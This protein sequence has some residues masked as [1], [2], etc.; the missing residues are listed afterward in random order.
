MKTLLHSSTRGS[1]LLVAM[2]FSTVLAIGLGSYLAMATSALGMSRRSF[3]ANEAMNVTEAGLEQALWAFNLANDQNAAGGTVTA[4]NSWTIIG[5]TARKTFTNFNLSNGCTAVVQ[6]VVRDYNSPGLP[7]PIVICKATVTPSSGPAIVKMVQVK[8]SRRSLFAVGMVGRTGV[9]FRGNKATVDSWNSN[10][11]GLTPS[12]NYP[13][14]SVNAPR[15]ANGSVSTGSLNADVSVG[16]ADIFGYVSVA[17]PTSDNIKLGP[18]GR[19]GG[20]TAGAGTIEAGRVAANFVEDL[21][22]PRAP[23]ATWIAYMENGN[24]R[25]TNS[26]IL[27]TDADITANRGV[28]RLGVTTYYYSVQSIST[29]GNLA[30]RPGYNVALR[31][32]GIG[33]AVSI[34]GSGEI[35]VGAGGKLAVYTSGDVSISGN[36]AANASGTTTGFEIWGTAT[37]VGQKISIKGK[38]GSLTGLVYAPNAD[39][40]INGDG[41]VAGSVVANSI[42][43]ANNAEFHYDESLITHGSAGSLTPFRAS[44]WNELRSAA[45]RSA[46]AATFNF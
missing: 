36:G 2:I 30:V 19:I 41:Y 44:R 38:G 32:T 43:V 9:E 24:N 27:P 1:V 7:Q 6:A 25:I 23:T 33:N 34:S 42:R 11:N 8:L 13:Y 45:D 22:V 26:T 20:F 21:P 37:T 31:A 16:N 18:Q 12:P 3:T 28:S 46:H 17:A 35:S 4:W 29:S 40:T 5:S 10:P 39:V 15:R 14:N